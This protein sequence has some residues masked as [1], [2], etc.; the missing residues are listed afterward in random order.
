MNSA[1]HNG[2]GN[3][4]N[5][6]QHKRRGSLNISL[7][8]GTPAQRTELRELLGALTDL[9]M[10]IAEI[11]APGQAPPQGD[12]VR[13]LMILLDEDLD[14]WD[15]ELRPWIESRNWA[16]VT[17][18]I[19]RRTPEAVRGALSAGANEVLFMPVD[20]VDL[21]RSL[22]TVSEINRGGGQASKAAYA[23]VSVSGGVGVSSLTVALGLALRRLTQKQVALVDLGL[24]AASLSAILDLE[25]VHSIGEL[26]DPTTSVDSIRRESAASKHSSGLYLLA[27]PARIEDGEMVSPGTIEATIGVMLQL[28]DYVLIDCGHHVNEGT[29]AAWERAGNVLYVL[30]Q[31]ITGVRA[32]QRFLDLFERLKLKHVSLDLLLNHYRPSHAVSLQKIEAAL[33]RPV[34][35]CIPHDEAALTA[36]EAQ[37][38]GLSTLPAGSP[39]LLAIERLA[40]TLIGALEAT[41]GAHKPGVFSRLI[42]AMS[43]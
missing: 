17:A 43:R 6:A 24:Q 32:T 41:D 31:S 1:Q 40:K 14:L 25:S 2:N 13:I 38:D 20:P 33:H 21:A 8:G 5:T 28:F 12:A 37:G 26:A 3:G 4:L 42:S 36:T 19:S 23:L 18:V 11:A 9:R 30:D 16:Q 10:D 29:V 27:A 34:A 15:E 7:A 35:F 22:W 39:L